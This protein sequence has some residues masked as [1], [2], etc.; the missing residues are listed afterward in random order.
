MTTPAQPAQPAQQPHDFR[1]W[2]LSPDVVHLLLALPMHTR[3]AAYARVTGDD[4]DGCPV[5]CGDPACGAVLPLRA[6]HSAIVAHR[7]T[8]G[9][10]P[11]LCAHETADSGQHFACSLDHLRNAL[12]A[13]WD[14]HITPR[15]SA[16]LATQLAPPP[17]ADE[18]PDAGRFPARS[19]TPTLPPPPQDEA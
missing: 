12:L 3:P 1:A 17:P 18:N 11:V 16:Q 4:G 19:S 9:L 14:T 10:A 13:C 7:Y 6:S 5:V 8:A 2:R 15:V